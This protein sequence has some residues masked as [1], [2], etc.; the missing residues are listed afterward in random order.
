MDLDV[1]VAGEPAP[2]L[3]MI[4]DEASG[5]VRVMG[6][7]VGAEGLGTL[8]RLA[9][10]EPPPPAKPARPRVLVCSDRAFAADLRPYAAEFGAV[11][12]V[13]DQLP[14]IDALLDTFREVMSGPPTLGLTVHLPQWSDVL[15]RL[16]VRAPWVVL[17]EEVTF[18]FEGLP[19]LA[20]R[21]GQL[22]GQAGKQIAV[23]VYD[24]EARWRRYMSLVPHDPERAMKLIVAS[25]VYIDPASQMSADI[26][27]RCRKD[28]LEIDGRWLPRACR[29]VE[30]EGDVLDEAEQ[31]ALLA[32][33]Q[34][35]TALCENDLPSLLRR[36]G[37]A[38][39]PTRLGL[40]TVRAVLGVPEREE[41]EAI[42]WEEHR[43]APG[44]YLLNGKPTRALLFRGS[45]GDAR[46]WV[47][48][49][50]ALDEIALHET[51]AGVEVR[52]FVA[53]VDRGL[54]SV[55]NMGP[56]QV[57]SF[58]AQANAVLV[59]MGGGVQR[60]EWSG[61][62]IVGVRPVRVRPAEKRGDWPDLGGI[63]RD[64]VVAVWGKLGRGQAMARRVSLVATAW[65]TSV[66][67]DFA[68]VSGAVGQARAK[69][70]KDER[71]ALDR[72]VALKRTRYPADPRQIHRMQ[73]P[74]DL[75]TE[76]LVVEWGLAHGESAPPTG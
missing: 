48:R 67:E 19:A 57:A 25:V 68:R 38:R 13:A 42:L 59:F 31:D 46:K 72:A 35:I 74:M 7:Q 58:R 53:G 16:V 24:D 50:R 34:A 21:R 43:V 5:Q 26:R 10:E 4:V 3:V 60:G 37:E 29:V 64:M 27:A 54:V 44:G 2:P 23:V 11:V 15:T 52:A 36:G 22:L 51:S 28:G 66:S 8:L 17:G 18:V 41:E 12:E 69:C 32:A 65:N 62:N 40:V 73:I 75:E 9:V 14:Q 20:G 61:Q 76:D 70:A 33:T 63:I 47:D 45:K 71:R 39:V 6:P 55:A 30:G 49:T 56:E 1:R